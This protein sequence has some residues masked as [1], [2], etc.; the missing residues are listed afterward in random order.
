MVAT[1][2][3]SGRRQS[4][5]ADFLSDKSLMSFCMASLA[6]SRMLAMLYISPL[7][8]VFDTLRRLNLDSF[9]TESCVFD[10]LDSCLSDSCL[11]DSCL[12]DSCVLD[13][14]VLN[15]LDSSVCNSLLFCCMT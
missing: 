8:F 4:A 13:S 1:S 9:L 11:S 6:L 3:G 2:V 15:V 12:S 14:F 5:L 7:S 10:V